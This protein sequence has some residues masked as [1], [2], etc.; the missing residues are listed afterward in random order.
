MENENVIQMLDN[1]HKLLE[2]GNIPKALNEI[3]GTIDMLVRDKNK[4]AGKIVDP[5]HVPQ[6][7][8]KELKDPIM[9]LYFEFGNKINEIASFLNQR[10]AR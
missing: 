4:K 9:Q 7:T 5:I 3:Q 2:L 1:I 6:F 8:E 10:F